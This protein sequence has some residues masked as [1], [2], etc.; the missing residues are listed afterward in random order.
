[1]HVRDIAPG[2]VQEVEHL[3]VPMP[4]GCRL[5]ARLWLPAD[6]S[7]SPVPA[8]LE[9]NP[10]RKR[11]GTRERDERMHRWFANEGYACVRLD[12]RGTGESEGR[13][14]DEY[15]EREQQ[16]TVEAIAWIAAQPWCNG[17]V[18]MIGKSWGGILALQVAARRPPA[19]RAVITVCSSDDRW[20]T[21]AHW[22]GGCSLV[23]NLSWGAMLG[24]VAAL[25][26]DPLLVGDTP[27]PPGHAHAGEPHWRAEW[28]ARVDALPLFAARWLA[29]TTRDDYWQRGSVAEDFARIECPVFAVSGWADAYADTVPRLLAGLR[30]PCKGLV[31]PWAHLYPHE[32]TPGPAI[33]F[34]QEAKR[35]WDEWLR[36]IDTGVRREPAYRVWMQDHPRPTPARHSVTQ[37]AGRWVAEADWPSARIE[38]VLHVL[39]AAGTVATGAVNA[40]SEVAIPPGARQ[41]IG[42]AAGPWCGFGIEADPFPEQSS[43]DAGSL[44]FESAALDAGIEILG[45]PGV[46]F[47]LSVDRP[48]AFLAVRLCDVAP[49][50]DSA[51]VSYALYDLT[52]RHGPERRDPVV[53]GERIRVQVVLRHAAHSFAPGHRLRV[54]VST[55][56]WPIVWPSPEPVAL[57]IFAAQA[58][59]ELPQRPS[60]PDDALLPAFAG[61]ES[62]PA[63]ATHDVDPTAI[64]SRETTDPRTGMTT[65]VTRIDFG[66][67]SIPART[68]FPA[69]DLETGHAIE[70]LFRIHPE[71]PLAAEARVMHHATRRRGAWHVEVESCWRMTGD[72][73][74][75]TITAE[76]H[77]RESG[78]TLRH[79]HWEVRVPRP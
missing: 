30:A 14:E 66:A 11:D 38:N 53:A 73:E 62:A 64:E 13:L 12:T 27:E 7:R 36:G 76:V 34:L 74:A 10:Y 2:S 40:A 22:M 44:V 39:P 41:S 5:A 25:P 3:W 37:R 20:L 71:D 58:G 50:G 51:R 24:T 59:L 55:A 28:L 15:S 68:S 19:L 26:P 47:E 78:K 6:A 33:G 56:Y 65:V 17:A 60:H 1:M 61:P 72:R 31:G 29:H 4:D 8:L 45:A 32:A 69:I 18:G 35:W 57:T 52:Q 42:L 9:C 48:S 75:F 77:A 67:G 23:E 21:D 63:D 54:A 46:S 49:N 16:D 43:D 70:E 79:R